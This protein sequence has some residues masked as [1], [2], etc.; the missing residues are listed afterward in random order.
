M[1]RLN[2]MLALLGLQ[3]QLAG[4]VVGVLTVGLACACIVKQVR[5]PTL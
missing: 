3:L 5:Q 2:I 1:F 4:V